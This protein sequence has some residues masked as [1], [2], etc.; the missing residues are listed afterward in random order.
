MASNGQSNG[1]RKVEPMELESLNPGATTPP[2]PHLLDQ[3]LLL[4][5]LYM[6]AYPKIA[7]VIVFALIGSIMLMTAPN[8]F[9][10]TLE[11][12]RL[13][14]DYSAINQNYNFKA[15]QMDHWC[16]WVSSN[17]IV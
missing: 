7:T 5:K 4:T 8:M 1:H 6:E 9:Q 2:P 16:L 13:H 12:H 10:S 14:H 15:S 3:L 17:D 11:R